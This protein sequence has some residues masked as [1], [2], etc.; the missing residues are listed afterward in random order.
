MIFIDE[1][2]RKLSDHFGLFE[3]TYPNYRIV[4]SEDQFEKRL[5][6]YEDRTPE[7]VFIREVTEVRLV[8][9]YRQWIHNKY[10][11][12]KLFPIEGINEKLLTVE[13]LSY[14]PIWTFEDKFGNALRP[15]WIAAKFIVD[16]IHANI[17]TKGY[18]KYKEPTKEEAVHIRMER[19]NQIEQS[20][21]GNETDLG[22]ALAH[23]QAI[24][25]PNG[26]NNE[27]SR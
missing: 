24:I 14:E 3:S 21:F 16:T 17:R 11:L 20:L 23:K 18:K 5:G 7:G 15:N 26:V 6:T 27:S 12:E 13:K 22:D 10:I 9:K 4:W 1:I 8:P 25:V 19:I 2:N